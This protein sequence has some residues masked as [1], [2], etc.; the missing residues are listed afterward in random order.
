[1]PR[2]FYEDEWEFLKLFVGLNTASIAG[3]FVAD[4]LPLP[5][6]RAAVGVPV[7]DAPPAWPKRS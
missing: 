3:I 1:M 7:H 6:L 4:A 2:P 5:G